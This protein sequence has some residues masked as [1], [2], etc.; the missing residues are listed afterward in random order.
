MMW[1]DNVS[2]RSLFDHI[3]AMV[4]C[5][6]FQPEKANLWN[7]QLDVLSRLIK[8]YNVPPVALHHIKPGYVK[9]T[10]TVTFEKIREFL[11]PFDEPDAKRHDHGGS[12]YAPPDQPIENFPPIPHAMD[13]EGETDEIKPAYKPIDMYEWL[14]YAQEG[15]LGFSETEMYLAMT[16]ILRFERECYPELEKL[17]FW[18]RIST[19]SNPYYIIECEFKQHSPKWYEKPAVNPE[20]HM[21][22]FPTNHKVTIYNP[23][24]TY[25]VREDFEET[26]FTLDLSKFPVPVVPLSDPDQIFKDVLAED[27]GT[28]ANMYCYY[29][30]Q[31]LIAAE[32]LRL[33]DVSPEQIRK[34]KFLKRTFKGNL[35]SKIIGSPTY[36]G[37]EQ[38][39]LRAQIARITH[40]TTI[41]PI[42]QYI[43]PEEEDET[44]GGPK[45]TLME[46]PDFEHPK[47]NEILSNS[48]SGYGH[49][50]PYILRQG[51]CTWWDPSPGAKPAGEEEEEEAEE[52]EEPQPEEGEEAADEKP[53]KKRKLKAKAESGPAVFSPITEDKETAKDAP[54][55]VVRPSC[56]TL[57]QIGFVKICSTLWP[58]AIC[59]VQQNKSENFYVGNGLKNGEFSPYMPPMPQA[60][61]NQ[62]AKFLQHETDPTVESENEQ[63]R[64]LEAAEQARLDAL[65]AAKE[66]AEEQAEADATEEEEEG[67]EE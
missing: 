42:G 26:R 58:G 24:G 45:F 62:K 47:L 44:E 59:I 18:G 34:A 7:N 53:K 37:V 1:R 35:Y 55:W 9:P 14:F 19:V 36:P 23:F 8:R 27:I 33:P 63:K 54:A 48:L 2:S 29:V 50:L 16:A 22:V 25:G 56:S 17:R 38:N 28:G 51:R 67:E 21:D 15:G 20:D 3:A 52:P 46:D 32:W 40:G 43:P 30:C 12:S 11:I 6:V 60:V 66:E 5:V 41:G 31:D 49:T 65:E 64:K 4:R 13:E 39:Y 10:E 57:P 61:F